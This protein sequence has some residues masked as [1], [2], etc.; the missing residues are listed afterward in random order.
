M[1]VETFA[2]HVTPYS[3]ALTQG[4]ATKLRLLVA[5]ER[6]RTTARGHRGVDVLY[7]QLLSASITTNAS[8]A[9]STP[10]AD[11]DQRHRQLRRNRTHTPMTANRGI[12]S[13]SSSFDSSVLAAQSVT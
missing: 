12:V 10:E 6:C 7:L 8:S 3:I 4:G 1:T 9:A 5:T 11:L 13:K 2:R